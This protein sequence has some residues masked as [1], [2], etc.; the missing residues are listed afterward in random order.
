[1]IELFLEALDAPPPGWSG[2]GRFIAL[3]LVR[4]VVEGLT[5]VLI[6]AALLGCL[7]LV[8]AATDTLPGPR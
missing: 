5:F 4:M 7:V 1:V 2:R 6:V 8:A 3:Q